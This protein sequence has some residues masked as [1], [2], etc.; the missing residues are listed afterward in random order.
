VT[1][2]RTLAKRIYWMSTIVR[3][4]ELEMSSSNAAQW[5]RA[6]QAW[7]LSVDVVSSD[8]TPAHQRELI[9][10]LRVKRS[11]RQIFFAAF[12]AIVRRSAHVDLEPTG[13]ILSAAGIKTKLE[14]CP[15]ISASS[16][17]KSTSIDDARGDQN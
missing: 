14:R 15:Y 11:E 4:E 6:H 12:S 2:S 17:D 3:K 13:A 8:L 1:E 7:E 5:E 9:R 10:T 16:R